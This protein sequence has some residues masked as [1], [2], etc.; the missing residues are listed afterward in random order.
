MNRPP[1]QVLH[2]HVLVH[3]RHA[4]HLAQPQP[5]A[6]PAIRRAWGGPRRVG[7][8]LACSG[9]GHA[10]GTVALA[11]DSKPPPFIQQQQQRDR[12]IAK[13]AACPHLTGSSRGLRLRPNSESWRSLQSST[14]WLVH[15]AGRYRK[16]N[17]CK[18]RRTWAGAAS[19]GAACSPRPVCN[20]WTTPGAA[21][22][23]LLT[24]A[25]WSR[26]PR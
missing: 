15:A 3:K 25:G 11:G 20:T 10:G 19:P 26:S 13:Q 5:P 18:E 7:V 2:D 1:A 22:L 17:R 16:P 21:R 9:I 4:A 24:S 6:V 12:N 14:E 23:P 8:G